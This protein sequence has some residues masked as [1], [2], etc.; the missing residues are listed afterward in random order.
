MADITN[1]DMGTALDWDT[2][3]IVDERSEYTPIDPGTYSFIVTGFERARYAGSQKMAPCPQANVTLSVDLGEG[4]KRQ[5]T[6]KLFLN[7][8]AMWKLCQFFECLGYPKDEETGNVRI[9]WDIIGKTGSCK[10]GVRTWTGN[11][12]TERKSNQV[13]EYL[14]PA[15]APALPTQSISQEAPAPNFSN[16]N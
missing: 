10:M 3:E 4:K 6:E 13:E 8:K 9:N 14:K 5:Y 12:G 2:T 16:W 1:N 15:A 7:S 11:D